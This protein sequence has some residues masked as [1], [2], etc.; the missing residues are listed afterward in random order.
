[1]KRFFLSFLLVVLASVPVRGEELLTVHEWGTIT[2]QHLD[3]GEQSG[4]LNRIREDELLPPFVH[5]F[6]TD[7][8][9]EFTKRAAPIPG[10]SWG[11]KSVNMR[12]ETPVIYFYP[13]PG[14]DLST[15]IDVTVE[16]K[17]G[18]IN[19]YF[20]EAKPEYENIETSEKGETNITKGTV[21]KITWSGV[22]LAGEAQ[23]PATDSSIWLAPRE[24]KSNAVHLPNGESEQ[25]LFYR[26][27]AHLDSLLR[28]K[29]TLDT[30][31]VS[32]YA[33]GDLPAY[34]A[35]TI[36]SKVWVTSVNTDGLAAFKEIGSLSLSADPAEPLAS[37]SV[38]FKKEDYSAENLDRLKKD[39]RQE[40]VNKGLFE[41]EAAAMLKTWDKAYFGNPGVR[42][43]FI[44]PQEWVNAHLP[45]KF[46]VPVQLERV[47]IGRIDLVM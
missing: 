43:F 32:I 27:V 10:A 12:L 18:L 8:L 26:G 42:I 37:V 6:D 4:G 9:I 11:H 20:P 29:H 14:F 47:I 40:L 35:N 16:F 21:G 46:S 22:T 44:V 39:M 30:R 33:P 15:P 7:F 41:E 34:L 19:E 3:S 31:V 17:G 36:L 25:Y 23:G 28:T 5:V 1:M 2:T 38:D 45:L 24:V 13:A